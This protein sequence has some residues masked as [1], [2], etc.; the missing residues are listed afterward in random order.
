MVGGI[1][2]TFKLLNFLSKNIAQTLLIVQSQSKNVASADMEISLN[3]LEMLSYFHYFYSQLLFKQYKK[4]S[5]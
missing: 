4:S 5:N 3:I 1:Y 2:F